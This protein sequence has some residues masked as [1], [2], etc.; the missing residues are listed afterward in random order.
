MENKVAILTYYWPP[1]G[2]PGVQRWLKFV[3]YLPDFGY[4]PFVITVSPEYA[5]YPLKDASLEAD[6]HPDARIFLTRS[7]GFYD[8]YKRLTKS[9]VPY[10][11]FVNEKEPDFL[12][13]TARFVRGNFFLPDARRGWN[14][15]AY[16]KAKEVVSKYGIKKLVTTGPPMSTH[17]VG[18]RLKRELGLVWIADF[19]DPWTGIYYYDRMYPTFLARKIDGSLERSVL[20]G[21]DRIITVSPS[22]AEEL[23]SKS[24]TL[25]GRDVEVIPNGYD[26]ADFAFETPRSR[27][28]TVTYTGTLASAYTLDAFIEAVSRLSREG[29]VLRLRFVG[30]VE[31]NMREKLET[32]DAEKEFIPFVPHAEAVRYMKE[33]SVLLLVIPN[34]PGNKGNLTGK[35]FEYIGSGSP[36]LALAPPDGD[37]A[38][39]IEK[40]GAGDV[41]DYTDAEGVYRY[42][43]RLM[44]D[45]GNIRS[46]TAS[47]Y[48]RKA[49]AGKLKE[50]L[51]AL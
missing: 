10:S 26:E 2:G 5:E 35:L 25:S 32:L 9:E 16:A 7:G 8:W 13:K 4:T 42:L 20:D 45:S 21:A 39:I 44:S 24:A 30:K 14:R 27:M 43:K 11:G 31:E 1:A 37:A 34:L 47:E 18:K 41:F 28:F 33:A 29:A 12:Q 46:A 48:S 36:I 22:L 49:L 19:R 40:T 23:S 51:D 3:R 15:F 17:L 50:I 6:V 38:S